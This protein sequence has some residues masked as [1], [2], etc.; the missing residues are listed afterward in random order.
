MA[1]K[2][3]VL[4][5]LSIVFVQRAALSKAT[6]R[7][8]VF[9]FDELSKKSPILITHCYSGDN[10]LG[11]HNL[12]DHPYHQW[13]FYASMFKTMRFSCTFRSGARHKRFDVFNAKRA[14]MC[15]T[16]LANVCSWIVKDDGFYFSPSEEYRLGMTKMYSWE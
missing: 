4:V 14:H 10:D 15:E 1:M 5:F 11:Y 16:G 3:K 6:S 9:I 2:T 12:H 8:E 13:S 7:Y